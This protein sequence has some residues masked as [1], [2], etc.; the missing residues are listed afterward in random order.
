MHE[1]V[2]SRQ[3]KLKDIVIVNLEQC[4]GRLWK[5]QKHGKELPIE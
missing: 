4:N 5:I 2:Q 3:Q 1:T